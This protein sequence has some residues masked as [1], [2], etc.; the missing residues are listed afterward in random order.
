M[1]TRKVY[2]DLHL[3][4]GILMLADVFKKF[5]NNRLKNH[6]SCPSLYLK[7]LCLSW[8]AMLKMTKIEIELIPDP[9]MYI[10]FEKGTRG[11]VP[12]ISNKYSKAN[13]KY[14]KS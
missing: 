11:R 2:H 12:Y 9:N 1:K 4:C 6:G 10:F 5:R 14:L 13:N 3:K 8:D 7:A